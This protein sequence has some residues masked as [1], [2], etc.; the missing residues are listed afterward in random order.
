[1]TRVRRLYS[2]GFA[3]EADGTKGTAVA[4][5]TGMFVGV[6]GGQLKPVA[7]YEDDNSSVGRIESGV[8]SYVTK[9]HSELQFQAPVKSNWIGHVLTGLLGTVSAANTSGETL[10]R[11]HTI[12]VNSAAAAPAYTIY[13][14]GGIANERA[15]YGTFQ[16]LKLSCE[17]GGLLEADVT[18]LAKSLVSATGTVAFTTD[19]QFQSSHG[20]VKLGANLAALPG[21][22][23]TKFHQVELTIERDTQP[24]FVFGAT[25]PDKFIPGSI[26]VSGT[27]TLLHEANTMR[28]H[29]T[30]GTEQAMRI[31]F[32]NPATIGTA[33]KPLLQI[34]LAKAH[35]KSHELSDAP[36]DIVMETIGFECKY[37]L[38]EGTPQMIAA[39][40]RNTQ[41]AT[42]YTTPA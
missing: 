26:K 37:D 10:V 35:F 15:P 13:S 29:Y 27:L 2:L 28:T 33:A 4:I 40:V 3:R 19:Y 21:A 22:T 5:S 36:D 20:S 23:A 30:A 1:M 11:D 6:E 7:E 34:D 25:D 31:A 38:D 32:E 9:T 18:L 42:A 24:H 14:L 12:T 17:A 39:L 41:A 16:S 8:A